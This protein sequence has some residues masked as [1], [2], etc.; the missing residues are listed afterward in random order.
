MDD[1][2]PSD[3]LYRAVEAV[4]AAWVV[5][6]VMRHAPH[7]THEARLAGIE[8]EATVLPVLRRLL[9]IDVAEQRTNP[10]AILRSTVKYPTG[11]LRAGGVAPVHRDSFALQNFPDDV[12]NLAPS[13]WRDLDDALFEPG[14][15]WGAWKAAVILGRR[16]AV[17]N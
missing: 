12:Y 13:T 9:D 10:L 3:S 4:L 15:M 8:A 6:S 2:S 7:L 1:A 14:M 11:V 5:R 17:E 16:R